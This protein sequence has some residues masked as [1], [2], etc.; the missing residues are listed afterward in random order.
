MI[1]SLDPEEWGA[2]WMAIGDRHCERA[3]GRRTARG[4]RS[5]RRTAFSPLGGSTRWAAGRSPSSPKKLECQAKA[6]SGV[7]GLWPVAD[8]QIETVRIPF[9][10]KE[11]VGLLQAPPASHGRRW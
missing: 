4:H 8:P 6:P 5:R 1:S 11:I 3:P 9:E 2:A 10:G 7:R